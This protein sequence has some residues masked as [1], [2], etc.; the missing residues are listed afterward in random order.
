ML[1][2]GGDLS[3]RDANVISGLKVEPELRACTKPMT[4][5]EC[6]VAGNPSLALDDLCNAVSWHIE[7]T[8]EFRRG[9]AEFRQLVSKDLARVN[10]RTAHIG[11]PL[12]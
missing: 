9:D 4:K 12:G 1:D 11:F 3:F 6:C 7:L 8:C 2:L 10:G 5:P